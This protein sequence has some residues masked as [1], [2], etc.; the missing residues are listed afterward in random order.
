MEQTW[1]LKNS[2]VT[3][4]QEVDDLTWNEKL[5][6]SE[7]NVSK[8]R[9]AQILKLD[10]LEDMKNEEHRWW[11]GSPKSSTKELIQ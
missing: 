2:L 3:T 11:W 7:K 1:K 6:G 9:R 8:K 4:M 5:V 10:R